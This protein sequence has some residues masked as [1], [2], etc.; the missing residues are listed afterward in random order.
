MRFFD[1][2]CDTIGA[3][4]EGA[5]FVTG[6]KAER[7][8]HGCSLHV[9]LPG[10]KTAGF[11][12]QVFAS[13]V[14]SQKYAGR[15]LETGLAKV[16][17]VRRLCEDHP[18]DLHLALTGDHVAGAFSRLADRDQAATAKI[19][20]VA[21]LEAADPLQGN[22]DNLDLFF[23]AGVR[24][25]T[26]AWGDNAFVGSTYGAG[27][28]LTPL[29]VDLVEACE[30]KHVLVDLSHASDKAFFDVCRVA[31]RPFV[32]S[33]SN[34]RALCPHPRNLTDEMIRMVGERGGVIG[35][36]LAPGFL[37]RDFYEA[38]RPLS[39]AFFDEIRSGTDSFEDAGRRC[40]A[41][42]ALLQR[43]P[44]ELLVDHVVHAIKVGGEDAVGLGGDLDG[45]DS[46]PA[47]FEGVG[48]YPRIA[49]LLLGAGL[50]ESRVE[51][52]CWGNFT[53]VCKEGLP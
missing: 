48:D 34:C 50:S 4:W 30:D 25:V 47:G 36:A 24:L 8:D 14:W 44:L 13:W 7:G 49:E 37:S 11:G 43:P 3:V 22:V 40:S 33:H 42:T 19:A 23:D 29:G 53:R 27:S 39:E 21:S 5:D 46:L 38:E 16:E 31:R 32:A 35:I 15:E 18:S 6:E 52:V 51:K 1:A 45:V 41:A 26:F 9:T 17:A 10:L 28:G 12:A 20:V 2:H